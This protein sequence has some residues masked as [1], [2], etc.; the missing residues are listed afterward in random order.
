[1]D[2]SAPAGNCL[3]IFSSLLRRYYGEKVIILIDEYDTPMQEAY[4][5]GY[6]DEITG[7]MRNMFNATL[8]TN[9]KEVKLHQK[10]RTNI[11]TQK[12]TVGYPG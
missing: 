5:N 11:R 2:K 7:F 9:T 4:V 12:M 6:W 10:H 3:N 8:K 1:M